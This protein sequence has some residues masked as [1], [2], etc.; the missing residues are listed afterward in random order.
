MSQ[1]EMDSP[2][3]GKYARD[4]ELWS[5]YFDSE[6]GLQA[7]RDHVDLDG[8]RVLDAG[9]GTGRLAFRL[10]PHADRV[11][12]IDIHPDLIDLSQE[13]MAEYCPE[14]CGELRFEVGTVT[15]LPYPD[16]Y[17]EIV[18]DGWTLSTVDDLTGAIA[19]YERLIPP[20]GALVSIQQGNDSEYLDLLREFAPTGG[21]G[22]DPEELLRKRLADRLGE[23]AVSVSVRADNEYPA[24]PIARDAVAF[25]LES[26]LGIDLDAG[27]RER[28]TDRLHA[29]ETDEGV[30]IEEHSTLRVY[31][32]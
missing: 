5:E 1:V 9:C 18:V 4:F 32:I 13:R 23:P 21:D 7:I 31:G 26:L 14:R 8:H 22:D 27:D 3:T 12:G 28:L 19:E 10:V 11:V 17:F 6:P 29:F 24:V 15:D 16:G 2:F 20:G 25:N 30:H